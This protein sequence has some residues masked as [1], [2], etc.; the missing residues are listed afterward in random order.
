MLGQASRLCPGSPYIRSSPRLVKPA[1]RIS[2]IAA[3]GLGGGVAA[4]QEAQ[5]GL[6]K[7][8]DPQAQAVNAQVPV[9][10]QLVGGNIVG[11]GFQ[12]D[13][14][15]RGKSRNAAAD[16]SSSSAMCAVAQQRRGPA[17]QKEGIKDGK[18][19][20][21]EPGFGVQGGEIGGNQGLISDGIKIAVGAFGF[22][23]G[24][25]NVE[26]GICWVIHKED[27]SGLPGLSH[28]VHVPLGKDNSQEHAPGGEQV[29]K[30]T[31]QLVQ[32]WPE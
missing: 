26:T 4:L 29:I 11:V 20:P 23:E 2:S 30:P 1:A 16:F 19:A 22:A 6:V 12:G 7:G 28:P 8:L 31:G 32:I 10:R 18:P 25:V 24:D 27:F 3:G 21:V 13:L 9:E 17:P 5:F 15:V 14:T